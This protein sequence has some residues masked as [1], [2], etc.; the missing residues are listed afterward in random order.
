MGCVNWKQTCTCTLTLVY[1]TGNVG[2]VQSCR[3]LVKMAEKFKDL[4]TSG[5]G[6]DF[7]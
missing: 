7:K 4:P 3:L 5:T 2:V 1:A 6:N